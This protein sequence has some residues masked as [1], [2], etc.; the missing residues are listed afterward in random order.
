MLCF[1]TSF[2]V[3]YRHGEEYTAEFLKLQA[4]RGESFGIPAPVEYELFAGAVASEHTAVAEVRESIEWAETVPLDRGGT[5]AAAEIKGELY[6]QGKPI[7]GFDTL[8]AGVVRARSGTLVT[9]EGHFTA[10]PEL[11]TVDPRE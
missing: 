6:D 2:L 11:S 8:I 5:V 10:V 3:D 7:G 9:S 1:D 4:A